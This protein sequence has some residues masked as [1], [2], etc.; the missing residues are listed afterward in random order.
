MTSLTAFQPKAA[1]E[2]FTTWFSD[3]VSYIIYLLFIAS[4]LPK[5]IGACFELEVS[6]FDYLSHEFPAL[7]KE[8]EVFEFVPVFRQSILLT[9]TAICLFTQEATV[10]LDVFCRRII[11]DVD[12]GAVIKIC[13]VG[14]L[15]AVSVAVYAYLPEIIFGEDMMFVDAAFGAVSARQPVF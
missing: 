1:S 11:R 13:E 12:V 8:V 2:S 14:N 3:A 15:V 4:Y 5:G 7:G 6:L 9:R 10:F